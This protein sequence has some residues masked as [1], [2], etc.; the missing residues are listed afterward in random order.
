MWARAERRSLR[1]VEA[2]APLPLTRA[3]RSAQI[4]FVISKPDVFKS[5]ASDTY[6]IFGEVRAIQTPTLCLPFANLTAGSTAPLRTS[7][8]PCSQMFGVL[9][10]IERVVMCVV[11]VR[12]P[13]SRT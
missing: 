2:L 12:R 3:V 1:V 5:P 4:L 10:V 13:R 6:I 7:A 11:C 8:S 9:G